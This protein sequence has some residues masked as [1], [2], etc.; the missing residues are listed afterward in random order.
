MK[1]WLGSIKLEQKFPAPEVMAKIL[2]GNPSNSAEDADVI[3]LHLTDL[4]VTEE[5]TVHLKGLLRKLIRDPDNYIFNEDDRGLV[6]QNIPAQLTHVTADSQCFVALSVA[7]HKRNLQDY[8][9]DGNLDHHDCF[10]L[11]VYLT[12]K[13]PRKNEESACKAILAQDVVITRGGT[14]IDVVLLGADLD[15]DD[16]AREVQL[17]N[18]QRLLRARQGQRPFCGL[19]WGDLGNRLVAFE[20]LREHATQKNGVWALKD[21]GVDLLVEMLQDQ[22]GRRELLGKDSLVFAGKDLSGLPFRTPQCNVLMR[23]L[24]ETHLDAVETQNLPVPLPSYKRSPIDRTATELLGF[25]ASCPEVVCLDSMLTRTSSDPV[26]EAVSGT[27]AAYFGWHS[28]GKGGA[29]QEATLQRTIKAELAGDGSKTKHMYLQLGWLDG[30]GVYKN[31]STKASIKWWETDERVLAFDHLPIR[32]IV[33]VECGQGPPLRVWLCAVKLDYRQPTREAL[34]TLLYGSN[35]A[36]AEDADVIALAFTDLLVT[37]SNVHSLRQMLRKVM[38]RPD[39]YVYNED[40]DGLVLRHIP[41]QLVRAADNGQRYVSLSVA[42]HKRNVDDYDGDG[43]LDLHDSFPVP[44]YLTCKS[45]RKNEVTACGK[46]ILAQDVIITRGGTVIDLVLLSAN[47]DTD[48]KAKL[49][50]L[51]ELKRLLRA[52]HGNRPFCA[53]IW[54]DLNNRLVAFEELQEHATQKKGKWV[55]KESGVDLLVKMID[56]PAGR[57]SLL[58]KDSLLYSGKDLAGQQFSTPECNV[59][60]QELFTMHVH[61]VQT[62]SLPVPLPSYKRSPLDLLVSASLGCSVRFSDVVCRGDGDRFEMGL[63]GMGVRKVEDCRRAYFGWVEHGDD[64]QRSIAPTCEDNQVGWINHDEELSTDADETS[65][66]S[67]QPGNGCH[68]DTGPLS[69]NLCLQ[70]GWP[71]GVGIYRGGTA[72]ARM[73]AWETEERVQAFDHLPIRATISVDV[74]DTQPRSKVLQYPAISTWLELPTNT[75]MSRSCRDEKIIQF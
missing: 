19:I 70:L 39:D 1:I 2:Y 67:K 40:D 21:S 28:K 37:K 68:Q 72:G 41:A 23:T 65:M 11:P 15:T 13:S 53:V 57:L 27:R 50:Q 69:S 64:V 31:D 9:G 34:E 73:V 75:D 25:E 16:V 61:A 10:P 38:R 6:L 43:T 63:S 7:V 42:V 48:D 55:L 30:V 14:V 58:H 74:P 45:P 5:N 46:A 3:A 49:G 33:E 4:V 17:C 22:A 29:A 44:V 26:L 32:S 60:L 18:A 66:Q 71:D 8:D 20:E 56:E 24:F 54:G 47:L 52:R 59:L 12:C 62:K 51:N 36:S 35:D